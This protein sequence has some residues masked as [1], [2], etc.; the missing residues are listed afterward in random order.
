[1]GWLRVAWR[2][3]AYGAAVLALNLA[4][5]AAA[6]AQAEG[7]PRV[8]ALGDSLTAGY[9]LPQGEGFVPELQGWL[10][11]NGVA[12]RLVNAGVS[13]DTTAGG[14]ARLDWALAEGADAAIVALGGN[15]MLRG[16]PPEVARA[17]LD[18]ILGALAA[19]GI[20]ALLIGIE[21]PGNYGPAYKAAFDGLYAD[22]AAEHD[23]LLEPSF[24]AP[25]TE[26]A[27]LEQ[28]VRRYM[29]PDGIHPNAEGV[30]VIVDA[31]GPRVAELLG[32]L[33]EG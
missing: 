14:L 20:P 1:M 25:L 2:S 4:L 26:A 5:T 3:C 18:G 17:N 23:A 15:D 24:L 19:R 11:E 8:L 32:R 28:A 30:E 27:P 16:L 12:A 7:A 10:D 22:L 6:L 21:A 31:F 33:G 29:Q 13:G 9:G